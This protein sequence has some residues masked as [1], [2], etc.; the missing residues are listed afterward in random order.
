M[1]IYYDDEKGML[2]PASLA[3]VTGDGIPDVALASFGE[4]VSVVD[5]A[6]FRPLWNVTFAGCETYSPAAPVT[7]EQMAAFLARI[8][9]LHTDTTEPAT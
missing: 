3:D 2:T 4:T 6:T 1:L 8:H 9:R 5:G 7:R